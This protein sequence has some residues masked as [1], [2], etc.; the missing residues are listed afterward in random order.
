MSATSKGM[1]PKR[2]N[3]FKFGADISTPKSSMPE[4]NGVI[5]GPGMGK[6]Q[7]ELSGMKPINTPGAIPNIAGPVALKTPGGVEIPKLNLGGK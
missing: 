6:T 5:E 2:R 4:G 1:T 3:F 7:H